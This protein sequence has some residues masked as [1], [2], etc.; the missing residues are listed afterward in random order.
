MTQFRPI[1]VASIFVSFFAPTAYGQ[2]TLLVCEGHLT[3]VVPELRSGPDNRT[4]VISKRNGKVVSVKE[5]DDIF[6]TSRADVS[7]EG[8]KGTAFRQLLVQPG[9]LILRTEYT[10]DKRKLDTV[11]FDTGQYTY[12]TYVFISRGKCTVSRKTF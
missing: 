4:F 11:L 1:L 9:K 3:S 8:K 12:E 6:T 2:D 5:D 10:S 7:P